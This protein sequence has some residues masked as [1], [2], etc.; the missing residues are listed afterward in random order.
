MNYNFSCIRFACLGLNFIQ[1]NNYSTVV[2]TVSY[3]LKA[4]TVEAEKQPLQVMARTHAAEERV[5]YAVTSRNNRRGVTSG[6][7]CG[8]AP[9][10]LL[11]NYAVN[12]FL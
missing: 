10:S 11:R 9:R 5:T 7:L 6:V 1:W 3:L 2:Y 4:R 12:T 8:S